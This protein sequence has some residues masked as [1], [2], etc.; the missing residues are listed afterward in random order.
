[1]TV[2]EMYPSPQRQVECDTCGGHLH[3]HCTWE[4]ARRVDC[5]NQCAHLKNQ[6]ERAAV[7]HR[8][9]SDRG[10]GEHLPGPD[11]V[12]SMVVAQ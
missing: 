10:W 12:L 4:G 9:L 8:Q 2:T 3:T 6:V 7:I 1:M 11:A 5:N